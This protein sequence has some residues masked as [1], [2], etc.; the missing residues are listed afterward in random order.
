[1]FVAIIDDVAIWNVPASLLPV[2]IK[3]LEPCFNL[4]SVFD[5]A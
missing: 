2:N 3:Y 1:M 4:T 5:G